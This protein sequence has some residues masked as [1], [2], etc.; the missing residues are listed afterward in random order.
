MNAKTRIKE[1]LKDEGILVSEKVFSAYLN[2]DRNMGYRR[3]VA[4]SKIVGTFINMWMDKDQVEQRKAYFRSWAKV[5]GFK[6][7]ENRGRPKK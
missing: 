5:N 3:A 6:Y 4:T 7:Y 1:L 2:G